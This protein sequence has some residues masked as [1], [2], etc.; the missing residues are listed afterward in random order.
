MPQAPNLNLPALMFA[1]YLCTR[2]P[3]RGNKFATAIRDK[4]LERSAQLLPSDGLAYVGRQQP[5]YP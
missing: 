4:R 1:A 2:C 5:T 3:L